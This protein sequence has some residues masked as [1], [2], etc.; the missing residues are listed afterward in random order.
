VL[1]L[2]GVNAGSSIEVV[3]AFFASL[4]PI[5]LILAGVNPAEFLYASVSNPGQVIG[6][7]IALAI[8]AIVAACA[9][10]GVVFVIHASMKRSFM[11]TV[12]RLSGNS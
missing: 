6:A 10:C 8:G 9:Y 5:N 7:R 12:R 11:M 1:G 2:C 3:G 4:S